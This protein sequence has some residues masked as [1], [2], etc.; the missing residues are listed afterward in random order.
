MSGVSRIFKSVFGKAERD[1]LGPV[2][3]L[4]ACAMTKPDERAAANMEVV[5]EEVCKELPNGG[6]HE[7]RKHI[8][9]RLLTA[10]KRGNGTLDGLRTVARAAMA[11]LSSRKSA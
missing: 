4:R 7:T 1:I 3:H 6:D 9:K 5:L 10:V 8:A 11:A 2:K